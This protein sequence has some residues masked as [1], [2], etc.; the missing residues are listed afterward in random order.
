MIRHTGP[1]DD[2]GGPGG[3]RPGARTASTRAMPTPSPTRI[4]QLLAALGV[5]AV[6]LLITVGG[7]GR[8]DPVLPGTSEQFSLDLEVVGRADH[9]VVYVVEQRA[10]PAYRIFEFDPVAGTERTVFTV[11]TN[12]LIYG[13][14]LSPDR[15]ALALAYTT[16]YNLDGSGLWTLNLETDELTQVTGVETDIYLTEPE[17]SA[18][19]GSVFMTRVDRSGE[20]EGLSLAEIELADPTVTIVAAN[21]ITPAVTG[22]DTYYLTVG[23][24]NARRTVSVLNDGGEDEILLVDGSEPDLD[25]LIAAPNGEDVHVAVLAL[26]DEPAVTVGEPA[27]AHGNHNVDSSWWTVGASSTQSELTPTI[28]YDAELSAE[29]AIVYATITGLVLGEIDDGGDPVPL[30][31]SR[32]IRFVAA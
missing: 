10:R 14:A 29:G 9:D 2:G 5:G 24:D 28:V 23:D 30:I 3:P 21:G 16:D 11:P 27:E 26:P 25:H 17:W 8:E 31:D 13:I 6:A 32:A 4:V 15:S 12:A 7:V 18:D 20:E 1:D 19:G 22:S